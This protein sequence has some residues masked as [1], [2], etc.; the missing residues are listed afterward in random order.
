MGMVEGGKPGLH[1]KVLS[2]ADPWPRKEMGSSKSVVMIISQVSWAAPICFISPSSST[3]V[4]VL[5][6]VGRDEEEVW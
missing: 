1:Y 4:S 2:Q 3:S 6:P 5:S